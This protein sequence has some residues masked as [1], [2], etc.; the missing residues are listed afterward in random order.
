MTKDVLRRRVVHAVVVHGMNPAQAV[1]AFRVSRTAVYRW[2][3]AHRTER[4][5]AACA[6][7]RSCPKHSQLAAHQE[8]MAL[9]LITER[10]PDRLQLP[11][12]LW[13]RQAVRQLLSE[14][15]GLHVS[16]WSAGRYLRRW[17]LTPQ[18]PVRRAFEHDPGAVVRWLQVEYT[19]IRTRAK[20]ENA[21]IHWGD[22]RDLCSDQ[23]GER[24]YSQR[25]YIPLI[26]RLENRSACS[27]VSTLTNRRLHFMVFQTLFT[28]PVL[29]AFLRRLLRSVKSKLFLIV[30]D[31]NVYHA[32][33]VQRWL[34]A[35]QDRVEL[36]FLPPTVS[37]WAR[38]GH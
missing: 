16:M 24:R 3:Q 14:R 35:R 34:A 25:R 13:T 12:A 30:E 31:H 26:Q 17:G 23:L 6:H 1:C 7:L 4:A 9:R 19:A 5:R 33:I 15:Y 20:L 27:M 38:R 36:F 28:Q 11:F 22:V 29:L 37:N 21:E 18:K 10:C 8:T 32:R 2:V